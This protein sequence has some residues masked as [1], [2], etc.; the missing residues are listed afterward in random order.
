MEAAIAKSLGTTLGIEKAK[1]ATALTDIRAA[2]HAR[3]AAAMKARLDK[4]VTVGTLTQAEAD[5]VTKAWERGVIG[6]RWHRPQHGQY[7]DMT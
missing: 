1:V 6:G 2:E 5:A 4:S 7:C 3:R